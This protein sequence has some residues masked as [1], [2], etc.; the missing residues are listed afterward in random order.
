[1][2]RSAKQMPIPA[3]IKNAYA[4]ADASVRRPL[5]LPQTL[6]VRGYLYRSRQFLLAQKRLRGCGLTP[7]GQSALPQTLRVFGV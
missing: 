7:D 2:H 1:M 5:A 6:R 3:G 4:G